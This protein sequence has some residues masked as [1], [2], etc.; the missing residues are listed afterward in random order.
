MSFGFGR[1]GYILSS[2]IHIA[3]FS[4]QLCKPTTGLPMGWQL[5]QGV[6]YRQWIFTVPFQRN[7]TATSRGHPSHGEAR[8][9]FILTFALLSWSPQTFGTKITSFTYFSMLIVEYVFH[10]KN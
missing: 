10:L 3:A 4:V 7:G 2:L 8:F 9:Y 1:F 6:S 5:P